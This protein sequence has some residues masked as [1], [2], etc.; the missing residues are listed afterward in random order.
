M[1]YARERREA[2]VARVAIGSLWSWW[3]LWSQSQ[4]EI[5]RRV[6]PESGGKAGK[7]R[8]D[9][10]RCSELVGQNGEDKFPQKSIFDSP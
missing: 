1:D 4:V 7:I 3:S 8:Q 2:R 6:D 9:M 10:V 5:R